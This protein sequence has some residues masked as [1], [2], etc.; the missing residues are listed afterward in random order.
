MSPHLRIARGAFRNFSAS[1]MQ[2][3]G[4]LM[5][6]RSED[7]SDV[8]LN[9]SF[10]YMLRSSPVIGKLCCLRLAVPSLS[11][12][13]SVY[14]LSLF[15]A[16]LESYS[17]IAGFCSSAIGPGPRGREA[18]PGGGQAGGRDPVEGVD[19]EGAAGRKG[20]H[21]RGLQITIQHIM[22]L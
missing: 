15:V 1:W 20:E 13:L 12:S 16:S 9:Q 21:A 19:G 6:F 2:G 11:Y 8:A 10:P 3:R 18:R 4:I 22:S 14:C 17:G 5:R 7:L